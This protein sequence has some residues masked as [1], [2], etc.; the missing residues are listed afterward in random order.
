T[1]IKF[2]TVDLDIIVYH[3]YHMHRLLDAPAKM[4]APGGKVMA[5]DP[6]LAEAYDEWQSADVIE[7]FRPEINEVITGVVKA[8]PKILG[9]SIQ[10]CNIR[11]AREIVKGVK[12]QLP[13]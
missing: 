7:Y 1:S 4:L 5:A 12:A 11:F 2:Q 13:A 10:A 3:R 6:W 8:R 9:I